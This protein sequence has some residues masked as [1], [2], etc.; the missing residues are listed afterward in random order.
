MGRA[1]WITIMPW[2]TSRQG[3]A[4]IDRRTLTD[5][6]YLRSEQYRDSGNLRA[7][8]GLHERFSTNPLGWQRWVFNQFDLMPDSR[9]L[10]LGCG[11]GRL[12]PVSTW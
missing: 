8:M 12:W 6:E 10:E 1:P 2:R 4:P 7:R 9:I 5:Q 11:P 3:S